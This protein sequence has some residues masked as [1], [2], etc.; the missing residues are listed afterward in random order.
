[1]SCMAPE[2][3]RVEVLSLPVLLRALIGVK[4]LPEPASF[5]RTNVV[6]TAVGGIEDLHYTL[7]YNADFCHLL[8]SRVDEVSLGEGRKSGI[9]HEL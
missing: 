1:M 4:E 2:R 3:D 8:A 5:S 7:Q 9:L 6:P